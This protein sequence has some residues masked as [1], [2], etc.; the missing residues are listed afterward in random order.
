MMGALGESSSVEE[1]R[2]DDG[3]GKENNVTFSMQSKAIKTV[4]I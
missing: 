2:K 3:P 1:K 4:E